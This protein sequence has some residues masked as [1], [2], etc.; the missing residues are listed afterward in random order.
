MLR[1]FTHSLK[2]VKWLPRVGRGRDKNG[3]WLLMGMRFW[4][5]VAQLC[6]YI[7]NHG[8]VHFKWVRYLSTKLLKKKKTQSNKLNK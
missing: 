1:V 5:V 7:K 6:E 2:A 4:G 8:T 3:K